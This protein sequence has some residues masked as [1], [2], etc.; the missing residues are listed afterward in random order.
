MITGFILAHLCLLAILL[1]FVMPRYYD[2]F[3]PPDRVT[4]GTE[5]TFVNETK[6]EEDVFMQ[7]RDPVA[8]L[9]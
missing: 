6:H 9:P 5:V 4:D 3:I 2:V 7:S 1:G 8:E